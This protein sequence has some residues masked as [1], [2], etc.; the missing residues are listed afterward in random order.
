MARAL[1]Q[2]NTYV[3]RQVPAEYAVTID[4]RK[5]FESVSY[6]EKNGDRV[7]LTPWLSAPNVRSVSSERTKNKQIWTAHQQKVRRF[8]PRIA[9]RAFTLDEEDGTEDDEEDSEADRDLTGE[10]EEKGVGSIEG[11]VGGEERAGGVVERLRAERHDANHE[12]IGNSTLQIWEEDFIQQT[13][14]L[15]EAETPAAGVSVGDLDERN[16]VPGTYRLVPHSVD[17]VPNTSSAEG[18]LS[19]SD[20]AGAVAQTI[21]PNLKRPLTSDIPVSELLGSNK[22]CKLVSGEHTKNSPAP[23]GAATFTFLS[24]LTSEVLWAE[25]EAVYNDFSLAFARSS[26]DEHRQFSLRVMLDAYY[27]T[28]LEPTSHLAPGRIREIQVQLRAHVTSTAFQ[29]IGTRWE[30]YSVLLSSVHVWYWLDIVIKREVDAL[31][32]IEPGGSSATGRSEWLEIL[33]SLTKSSLVAQKDPIILDPYRNP[34]LLTL[35]SRMITISNRHKRIFLSGDANDQELLASAVVS[36]V[37]R[38]LMDC[39]EFPPETSIKER[40]RAWLMGTLAEVLGHEFLATSFA[41][42]SWERFSVKDFLGETFQ[43][44]G[45]N[46]DLIQPFRVALAGHSI[47]QVGSDAWKAYSSFKSCLMNQAQ[48]ASHDVQR[49]FCPDSSTASRIDTGNNSL[50]AAPTDS[51][52]TQFDGLDAYLRSCLDYLSGDISPQ[53]ALHQF[54]QEAPDYR[55][56]FREK[57]PSR[58][59]FQSNGGPYQH[60]TVRT[61]AGIFSAVIYRGITYNTRFS[62]HPESPMVFT[63]GK[64]WKEKIATFKVQHSSVSWEKGFFCRPDAYGQ[65]IRG[66]SVDNAQK[67]WDDVQSLDWPK[68][69]RKTMT[70]DECFKL[71]R[72]DRFPTMGNLCCYLL[73]CDLH[74]A[75]ICEAPTVDNVASFI[76][77]QKGGS[78]HILPALGFGSQDIHPTKQTVVAAL[79][80]VDAHLRVAFN[81]EERRLMGVEESGWIGVEHILCKFKRAV[82]A[83]VVAP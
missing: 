53:S 66:R 48:Y 67:F 1:H 22:R 4:I 55:F 71:F 40:R 15:L 8:I 32:K 73:A 78:Y 45:K 31:L 21:T 17:G 49:P 10:D 34:S 7:Q 62:E 82:T 23:R 11:L 58:V 54:L 68:R 44:Y 80:S 27:S 18:V 47:C 70:F 20:S 36:T 38:I 61:N 28:C 76:R 29:A 81:E 9:Y 51:T 46:P 5:M 16:M 59:R 63:D 50:N 72:K 25:A 41:W 13:L 52:Q 35:S 39:L 77:A 75:G 33:V 24:K 64:D 83:E 74:Y 12:T 6:E 30:R 60:P 57:A 65:G 26:V 42:D 3:W 2:L 69:T 37:Q 79:S 19:R 56:P 43:F 14:L